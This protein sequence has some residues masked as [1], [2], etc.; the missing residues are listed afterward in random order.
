MQDLIQAAARDEISLSV[1]ALKVVSPLADDAADS[2]ATEK[3]K[4]QFAAML[5]HLL[6]T[7][8]AAARIGPDTFLAILPFTD[9][10]GI[11]CVAARVAAIADCTTFESEDPLQPFRLGVLSAAVEVRP[12]ETAEAL[13]E[14]AVEKLRR[15]DPVAAIG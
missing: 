15:N 2:P 4:R 1:L 3:A 12:D 13:I 9:T 8:D 5:R 7:E 6:R 11:D 14:R 10:V